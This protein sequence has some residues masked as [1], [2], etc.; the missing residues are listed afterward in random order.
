MIEA[1]VDSF[2]SAL[3][4]ESAGAS[5]IE[6]CADLARDGLTP[7]WDLVARCRAALAI[8]IHVMIRPRAG[9][10]VYTA[11]ERR[12]MED[13]IRRAGDAGVAG[14][15]FGALRRSAVIDTGVIEKLTSLSIS[16]SV[17]LSV[18]FHRA[19]DRVADPLA[20]LDQLIP[21]R[22]HRVLTSGGAPSAEQGIPVL[23]RLVERAEGRIVILAGG[24]I[25]GTNA[26]RIVEGSGVAE[27]HVG[28]RRVEDAEK[29]RAV[30]AA[31][32]ARG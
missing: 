16:P 18:C 2:D 5:R 3:A 12:E 32:S 29:I 9:D 23:R 6:L 31:L 22:V 24:G 19:F 26:R 7:P 13:G 20:A 1:A 11:A 21:L 17:R 8:P 15:V 28:V 27:V 4:A 25:N 14:V 10:F 30:R